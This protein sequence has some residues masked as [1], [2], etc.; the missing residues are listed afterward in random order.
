MEE[1][2]RTTKEEIPENTIEI[3]G[4]L[5]QLREKNVENKKKTK[6]KSLRSSIRES[7]R[8]NALRRSFVR[9]TKSFEPKK[10][11]TNKK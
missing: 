2:E 8:N 10:G 3:D 7:F 4:E 1:E 6:M 11:N 9:R 5:V